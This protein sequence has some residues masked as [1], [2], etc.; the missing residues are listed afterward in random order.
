MSWDTLDSAKFWKAELYAACLSSPLCFNFPPKTS[1][2]QSQPKLE[3]YIA[4]QTDKMVW[5]WLRLQFLWRKDLIDSAFL[6]LALIQWA[7]SRRLAC[8]VEMW[9]EEPPCR[10]WSQLPEKREITRNLADTPK[11]IIYNYL[12]KWGSA[13]FL[14]QMGFWENNKCWVPM[15]C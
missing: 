3:S 12:H 13:H 1:A 8:A 6:I 15:T 5:P 4:N 2:P 9:A 11:D 7:G 10:L 14:P